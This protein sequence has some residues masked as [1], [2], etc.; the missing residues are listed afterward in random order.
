MIFCIYKEVYDWACR[1]QFQCATCLPSG[2]KEA[3][4]N[5][6]NHLTKLHT[7][8]D[9]QNHPWTKS[10]GLTHTDNSQKQSLPWLLFVV[11]MC[12]NVTFIFSNTL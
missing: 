7:G 1:S 11:I 10:Q 5:L 3:K 9:Y 2:D 12:G 4:Q 8:S 6:E